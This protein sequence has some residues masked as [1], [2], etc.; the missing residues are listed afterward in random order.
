MLLQALSERLS[1]NPL[2]HYCNVKRQTRQNGPTVLRLCDLGVKT[3]IN[4]TSRDAAGERDVVEDVA[5]GGAE[6]EAVVGVAD[7]TKYE[8]VRFGITLLTKGSL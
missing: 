4:Q 2:A 3:K 6:G 5:G 1:S 7:K 8:R